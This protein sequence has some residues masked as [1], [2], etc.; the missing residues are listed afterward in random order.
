MEDS[1]YSN[2]KGGSYDNAHDV[3]YIAPITAT[4]VAA[5][6]GSANLV[7]NRKPVE[8]AMALELMAAGKTYDEVQEATGIGYN[9]LVGLKTRHPDTLE[10]RRQ[11]MAQD[12]FRL[13]E[14]MRMLAMKKAAMLADDEDALKKVNLKDLVIPYAIAQDKGFS[15]LEGNTVRVEHTGKKMTIQDAQAMIDEARR[16]LQKEAIP[17]EAEQTDA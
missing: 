11:M 9:A 12:G 5:T 2:A 7:E 1:D 8:A 3:G 13:A 16:A 6:G 15:A 17:V 10:K 4:S 14:A